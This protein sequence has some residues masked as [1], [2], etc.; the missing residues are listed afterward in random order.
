VKLTLQIWRQPNSRTRGA[1]VTYQLEDLSQHMSFLEALDV[2]NERLLGQGEE[3]V[4]FDHDCREGI[5]GSC[6]VMI[7]GQPHGPEPAT[8]TCQVHLRSFADG[9]LV[10]VEPWRAAGFPIIKDLS[11]DRSAF[12]RII[13]AGGF[14]S[15]PTGSAP[16]ANLVPIPKPAAETAMDAAAC[17]GC[18]A[19]V[20][21]CPNRAA[22]LFVG[23]KLTHLNSL[24]QGKPEQAT[25]V[26]AMVEEMERFFG[27]CTNYAECEAAC[28]KGISID[29]IAR[30]NRDY[31]S[32]KLGASALSGK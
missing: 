22:Q 28:P 1:F 18:G 23:A 32:A 10:V 11:V 7:N 8:A 15:V 26:L 31:I 17:I 13:E 12:D 5:C 25:R 21:A 24:P 3:P 29:V 30:L 16:E 27:S 20:A 19:C 14:V 9:D 6:G 2:L 4:A